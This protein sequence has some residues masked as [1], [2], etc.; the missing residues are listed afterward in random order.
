MTMANALDM[1]KAQREAAEA[2]HARLTEV[3]A[4]VS[5][6]QQ[7]LDRLALDR[8]LKETLKAEQAWLSKVQELIQQEQAFRQRQFERFR[9]SILWRWVLACA[10]AL[11]ALAASGAGYVWAAQPY[12][13]ELTQLRDQAALADLIERRLAAMTPAERQQFERLLKRPDKTEQSRLSASPR[14]EPAPRTR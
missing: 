1:F 13:A 4:L 9:L 5:S 8:T 7:A 2:L 3:A 12:T 10:F 14:K 11:A 6:L